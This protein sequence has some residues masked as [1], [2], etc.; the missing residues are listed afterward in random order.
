MR[1]RLDLEH[2]ERGEADPPVLPATNAAYK[3]AEVQ[4]AMPFSQ[5]LLQA[6]KSA[7]TRPVSPVY[8]QISQA[9]Y[10][11]VGK[12]LS[13]ALSPKD[14]ASKMAKETDAAMRTF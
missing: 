7:K 6:L 8:P 1:Q 3:S 9:I 4:K 14:A 10:E 13:G 5:E 2:I 11:A 12:V